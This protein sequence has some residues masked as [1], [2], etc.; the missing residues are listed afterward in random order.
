MKARKG[1]SD[2]TT[3]H[4]MRTKRTR[5]WEAD[6][7]E[8]LWSNGYFVFF[9]SQTRKQS[10]W[11]IIFEKIWRENVKKGRCWL[12]EESPVTRLCFI[13]YSPFLEIKQLSSSSWV[14]LIIKTKSKYHS[15][16]QGTDEKNLRQK[17][18]KRKKG[19]VFLNLI[20]NISRSRIQVDD[21]SIRLLPLRRHSILWR[22]NSY[23]LAFVQYL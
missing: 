5:W 16:R 6:W 7:K 9:W 11:K 10:K 1:S 14:R 20:L 8:N 23:L 17:I 12:V 3:K 18:F 21:D 15:R 4:W 19:E 2:F 22:E 13:C